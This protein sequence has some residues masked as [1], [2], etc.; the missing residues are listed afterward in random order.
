MKKYIVEFIGTFFLVFIVGMSVIH[1][2]LFAPIAIGSTLMVMVYA[3]GHISGGHYNPAVTTAV[4]I[5]GAIEMKEALMYM[6]FQFAG[7]IVAGIAIWWYTAHEV[8][9]APAPNYSTLMVVGAEMLGIFALCYVVLNSATHPK[10]EGNSF[11]G[12]AIGFTVMCMAY[13]LGDISGGAF[14]PAVGMGPNIVQACMGDT[15][16]LHN[17]WIYFV[18]PILGGVVAGYTYKFINA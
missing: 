10:T 3:G 5:R 15:S 9:I 17:I 16:N 12:L 7:A 11:Y 8:V 13:G 1:A 18:G 4:L 2:G 14:N 6:V